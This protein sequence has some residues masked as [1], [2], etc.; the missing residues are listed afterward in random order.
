VLVVKLRALRGAL[1]RQASRPSQGS[2]LLPEAAESLLDLGR[3]A[4]V[5][6]P[7]SFCRWHGMAESDHTGLVTTG[8][9]T[10]LSSTKGEAADDPRSRNAANR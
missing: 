3:C 4:S 9:V 5:R 6:P 7:L 1:L 8:L 2:D 10:V